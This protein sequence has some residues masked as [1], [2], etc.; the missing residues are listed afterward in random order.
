M[1]LQNNIL[2]LKASATLAINELSQKLP[3]SHHSSAEY[4]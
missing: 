3:A 2:G 4:S 1:E